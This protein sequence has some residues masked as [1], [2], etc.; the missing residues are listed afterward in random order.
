MISVSAQ[1][2]PLTLGLFEKRIQGDDC[3]LELARLRFQQAEMGAE[4]HVGS[5]EQ[6]DWMLGFRPSQNAPVMV[7]LPRDCHL[8]EARGHHLIGDLAARSARLVN[9]FVIHDHPEMATRPD[10]FIAAA[11]R[12]N[13]LL[14]G[15]GQSPRL[16]IEYAAGLDP[17]AYA[18]FFES[19]QGL[20]CISTCIDVG[21]V[22]IRQVQEAYREVHPGEDICAL[23]SQP[24]KLPLFMNDVEQAVRSA[25]PAVLNLIDLVGKLNKPVHFHLHDGHPLS[26]FSPFG[27]SDHLSFLAEIPLAFEY[28]DRR[29]VPLMFGPEGLAQIVTK[30]VNAI[31]PARVSFTLEIHPSPERLPL[32]DASGLFGHWRDKTHAEQMNH[33]LRAL[34]DNHA[35]LK[36]AIGATQSEVVGTPSPSS[37]S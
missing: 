4:I 25:L 16:F 24:A 5:P 23:K 11:H 9:G 10:Q 36:Q 8:D 2:Q 26:T 1:P 12:L 19:V 27:V 15:I 31:G 30:A 35:L 28:R 29:A 33:W 6:L 14:E 21:H 13:S 7:H 20:G 32:G 18:R 22:G 34:A 37:G 17:S 3:L